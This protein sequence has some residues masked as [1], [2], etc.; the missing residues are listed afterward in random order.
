[1]RET[2]T[3]DSHPIFSLK[4]HTLRTTAQLL[5]TP[6]INL[7][8]A[9]PSTVS[10]NRLSYVEKSHAP[11]SSETPLEIQSAIDMAVTMGLTPLAL[12]K[13]LASAT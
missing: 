12:G 6:N 4:C 2:R 7:T 1:M 9:Y 3:I 13:T 8:P 10:P 5:L 11:N